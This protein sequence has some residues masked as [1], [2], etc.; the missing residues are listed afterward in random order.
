[1]T[2]GLQGYLIQVTTGVPYG[3]VSYERDT[4]VVIFDIHHLQIAS[5][6]ASKF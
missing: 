3:A 6:P 1:M 2:E 5:L 4:P